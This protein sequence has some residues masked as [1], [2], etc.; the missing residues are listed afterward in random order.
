[1]DSLW[2]LNEFFAISEG[3]IAVL[4]FL[5]NFRDFSGIIYGF[6]GISEEFLW[7]LWYF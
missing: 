2:I 7:I 1:M 3:F 5:W 6:F 4:Q